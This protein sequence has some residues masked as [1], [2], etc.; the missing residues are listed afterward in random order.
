[1][2]SQLFNW[3]DQGKIKEV[4]LGEEKFFIPN[5]TYRDNHDSLLVIYQLFEWADSEEKKNIV[6]REF[7]EAVDTISKKDIKEGF[8]LILSYCI[9]KNSSDNY[10][11]DES[12]LIS[13]TVLMI[14]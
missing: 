3:F 2:N 5:N 9:A 6:N 12:N 14:G 1:M 7:Y 8:R 13:K 4:L 11:L 10:F